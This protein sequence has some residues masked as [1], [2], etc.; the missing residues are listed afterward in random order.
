MGLL[1][2][3][4]I[5]VSILSLGTL[6]GLIIWARHPGLL[7][8]L[9]VFICAP[10]AIGIAIWDVVT[11]SENERVAAQ[12]TGIASA[13]EAKDPNIGRFVSAQSPEVLMMIQS[14]MKTVDA[15]DIRLSE[16]NIR[17]TT[18]GS[19]A[20][21]NFRASADLN[22]NGLGGVGRQPGSFETIWTREDNAWK[23]M[24]VNRKN[25]INGQA[26]EVTSPTA[27]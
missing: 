3:S 6:I 14:G 5:P 12:L 8:K 2:E 25:P 19:R 20:I 27:S 17:F 10:L 16:M 11:I 22:V 15:R 9:L 4:W 13:F 18:D 23:L 26:M 21:V 24:R 1:S 7:G